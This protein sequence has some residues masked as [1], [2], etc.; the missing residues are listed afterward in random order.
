MARPIKIFNPQNGQMALST[1]LLIG[2]IIGEIGVGLSLIAFLL[3]NSGIGN[4]LSGEA[5]AAAHAGVQ[6]AFLRIVRDKS[7]SN[8][9]YEINV[10][11]RIANVAV[12]IN[13]PAVGKDTITSTG[14][15][16]VRQRKIQA[17]VVIDGVTGKVNLESVVEA[18]L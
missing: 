18:A 17:I 16:S 9:G 14:T 8:A 7:F 11:S 15:A 12:V 2:G 5:L 10:G 3:L 13:S 4:R 6:D 1:T